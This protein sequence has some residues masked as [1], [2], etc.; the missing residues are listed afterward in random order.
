MTVHF[1]YFTMPV[2]RFLFFDLRFPLVSSSSYHSLESKTPHFTSERGQLSRDTLL[3][4][5]YFPSLL[6]RVGT[7]L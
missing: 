1:T 5:E 4:P 6:L 2:W 3:E 7:A